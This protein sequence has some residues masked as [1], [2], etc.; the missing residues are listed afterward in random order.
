[1]P[2]LPGRQLELQ[3]CERRQRACPQQRDLKWCRVGRAET[4][5]KIGRPG[6]RTTFSDSSPG[7]ADVQ[8]A[9]P[10]G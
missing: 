3:A 7:I 8:P 10:D 2:G 1:M 9:L 6:I 4:V 5:T